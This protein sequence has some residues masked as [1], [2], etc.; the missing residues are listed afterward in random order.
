[1]NVTVVISLLFILSND[2]NFRSTGIVAMSFIVFHYE[3]HIA[4]KKWLLPFEIIENY[5]R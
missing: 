4:I 5:S 3:N 1:M 2:G